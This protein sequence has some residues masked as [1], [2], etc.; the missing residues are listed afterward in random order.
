M[1]NIITVV[2]W[3][4]L[5]WYRCVTKPAGYASQHYSVPVP[6]QDKLG[7]LWQKGHLA[8]KW[9]DD[10]GGGT[11]SPDGVASRRIVGASAST[12]FCCIIKSRIWWVWWSGLVWV[13]ECFFWY[14][15]TRVIPDKRPLNGCVCRTGMFKNERQ[16]LA[17]KMHE[18]W[19]ECKI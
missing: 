6:S 4:R 1:D 11:D 14:R 8:W 2:Q 10:G 5:R 12:V 7:G 15:P 19:T 9:R 3:N 18:V 16:W 13:G 17:E